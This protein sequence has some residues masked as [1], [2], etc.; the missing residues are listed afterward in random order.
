[1]DESLTNEVKMQRTKLFLF[2]AKFN[3]I[4]SGTGTIV[5]ARHKMIIL[6]RSLA[7]FSGLS[8]V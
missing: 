6:S 8:T 2:V 7:F 4:A 5:G 3:V 1:M